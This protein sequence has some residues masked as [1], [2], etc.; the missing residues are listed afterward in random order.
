MQ[1]SHLRTAVLVCP[2]AQWFE[3]PAQ[4][5]SAWKCG[6][7]VVW[8]DLH[9][10]RAGL[11]LSPRLRASEIEAHH[12]AIKDALEDTIPRGEVKKNVGESW[13]KG[14]AD[15]TGCEQWGGMAGCGY[16]CQ[17]RV[18]LSSDGPAGD[19][20]QMVIGRSVSRTVATWGSG[21]GISVLRCPFTR[22]GD[23]RQHKD[24]GA[25]QNG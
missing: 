5:R 2:L 19:D 1:Q 12:G 16:F 15:G 22:H 21:S 7:V 8:R 11:A 18:A 10:P 4:H 24:A 23:K 25:G 3:G 13:G 14:V 9:H 17:C 20:P 6:G